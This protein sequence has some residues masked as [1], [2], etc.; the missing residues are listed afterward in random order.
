MA[1][2]IKLSQE[3]IEEVRKTIKPHWG[4][5]GWVTYKRTYARWIEEEKRTEEWHETVKRVV[6]G[7]INLDPRLKQENVP[8][9][10]IHELEEEAKQLYKLI[11]GLA[12]AASG[13]NL[14]IS[15]TEFQKRN[16][17]ALNN[18]WFKAIRPQAY[19]DSNIVPFY[20]KDKYEQTVS[21]PFSFIFDQL[22]KGGGVGFS[23]TKEN[24]AKMPKVQKPIEL[25]VLVGKENG[26]YE[27]IVDVGAKDRD[28]FYKGLNEKEPKTIVYQTED[29]REG[30]VI[31]LA[32]VIDSHFKTIEDVERVVIDVTDVREEGKRIKGFGGVASGAKP[33]AELL[34]EVN[35]ML[36]NAVGRRITSVE[37]TDIANLIGK[38]VVAGN[39]RRSAEIALGSPDDDEFILMKQDKE[40]LMSHR[41]ASNNSVIIDNSFDDYGKI[42]EAL[43]VNGEPAVVNMELARNYGRI[44]DG[45]QTGIDGKAEG[46]NPCG[47]V[48]LED[49]ENCNLFEIFPLIAEKQGWDLKEAFRLATRY[50][51][52]V[53]FSNYEWEITRKVV[54]KNRRIG[55]SMSGI[56]DW[57]L[58]R[59][60]GRLVEGFQLAYD[61]NGEIIEEP[62]F[63]Q[64]AAKVVDELYKAVVEADKE[65]SEQL[66]CNRSI[67]LTTVKP[68]GTVSKLAGVSEGIHYHY[69]K[70]IIQRIRFQSNDPILSAIKFAGYKTEPDAYSPNT[71]VVEFLVKAPT[72]EYEKFMS[73]KDVPIEE[74]FAN[75]AF[76]QKYWADNS[77]SITI[78]FKEDEKDKIEKLLRQYRKYTKSTT[79]L[80][81]S[82][83]GY[84]QAPKEPIS[85]EEYHERTA[86]IKGDVQE[87]YNLMQEALRFHQTEQDLEIVGQ[88]DCEGGACP[89]K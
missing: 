43:I 61:E 88:E 75:Q 45:E 66:G 62:I 15:G 46:T 76:M 85:E 81:F 30:W 41:W 53:T 42:A 80:P 73:A 18:C 6:E 47:E 39:V 74:Q 4:P 14:W 21:M 17:D 16:G 40:K 83:H 70:Y 32:L 79:L 48:T 26:D 68:S 3:F 19:G 13:R 44:V 50:A 84:V 8:L 65:Y 5:L 55:I 89:V 57:V 25:V 35:E 2:E 87:I 51:K 56:Q 31:S 28:E 36:N 71:T 33:L 38:T 69:D 34:F 64:E 1:V 9:P 52:R 63:N 54:E 29:S 49:G 22:M 10:V 59:F 78:T 20:L 12:G 27:K 23:V 58:V 72:A 7:N 11:Y 82:G 77:V 86:Q 37:A 24:M 60:G 67:K